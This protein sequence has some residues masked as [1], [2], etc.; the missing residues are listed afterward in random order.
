MYYKEQLLCVFLFISLYNITVNM[1]TVRRSIIGEDLFDEIGELLNFAKISSRQMKI[2]WTTQNN[3]SKL[4]LCQI[5]I[6][7]ELPNII[8]TNISRLQ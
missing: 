2:I 4:N 5:V 6:F 3:I 1:D 8:V 7:Y